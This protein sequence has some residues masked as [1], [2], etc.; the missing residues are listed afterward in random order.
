M[1]KGRVFGVKNSVS[2]RRAAP[3][4]RLMA[5]PRSRIRLSDLTAICDFGHAA[6]VVAGFQ[7]ISDSP[8]L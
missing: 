5:C 7:D 8:R 2:E 3:G 6:V 1:S 4:P